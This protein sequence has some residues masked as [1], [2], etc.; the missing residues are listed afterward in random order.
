MLK[1]VKGN[2]VLTILETEDTAYQALGYDVY[3]ENDKGKRTLKLRGHGKKISHAEYDSLKAELEKVKAELEKV[4][5][6]K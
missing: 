1:A 5:A 3:A 2:K 6:K 4:Q